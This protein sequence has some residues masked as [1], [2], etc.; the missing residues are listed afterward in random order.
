MILHVLCIALGLNAIFWTTHASVLKRSV[1]F[2][3]SGQLAGWTL[4]E[5]EAQGTVSEAPKVFYKGPSALKMTQTFID[6]YKDRYHSEVVYNK[7][8][9]R[10]DSKYYGFAFRLQEAWEFDEQSY[11][12]AQWIADFTDTGC[13]D[14][15]PTTMVYLRGSTLYSRVK[16]GQLIP[17]KPC[18]PA[19]NKGDCSGGKNCQNIREFAL[20]N[21][22]QGGVWYRVVFQVKWVADDTGFFK[23]W[24]N[25]TQVHS[26]SGIPTTLSDD[27]REFS[28]RLGIYANG[29]H[30]DNHQMKGSQG[31]RQVWIDEV[32]V[33]STF[34]DVDP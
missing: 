31:F 18:P 34:A 28:F 15:S 19:S 22:I 29:W 13:D 17:G 1:E 16:T 9:H 6:G 33:G 8:Y 7:G 27:G 3:N 26:E 24:I 11:N 20:Q 2:E 32:G 5:P 25:G 30:D 14:W 4:P 21:N 10:G 23:T 12:I